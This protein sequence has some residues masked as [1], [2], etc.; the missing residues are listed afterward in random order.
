MVKELLDNQ[1]A[2]PTKQIPL[3]QKRNSKQ[4]TKT[5]AGDNVLHTIMRK[6]DS[7]MLTEI[8]MYLG[9]AKFEE[10]L[11]AKNVLG[12]DPLWTLIDLYFTVSRPLYDVG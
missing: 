6:L 5:L 11:S 1:L 7:D 8:R 12:K 2:D 3:S 10:C 9:T 4:D